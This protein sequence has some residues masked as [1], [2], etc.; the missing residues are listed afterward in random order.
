LYDLLYFKVNN[1]NFLDNV[2]YINSLIKIFLP[3]KFQNLKTNKVFFKNLLI[4]ELPKYNPYNYCY[5][6][7][8]KKIFISKYFTSNGIFFNKYL[9]RKYNI[10]YA[11]LLLTNS[12]FFNIILDLKLKQI[13]LSIKNLKFNFILFLYYLGIKNTD[14]L[15]YSRYKN[16]KI[17]KLLIFSALQTDL[18]NNKKII[19]KNLNY[20]KSIFKLTILNKNYKNFIISKD[21]LNYNYGDFSKNNLLIID[22]IFILDL[23]LDLQS[24][25]LC[26]KTIDHLDNKHINTIGNYFQHNFKFYLK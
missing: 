8:L 10:Y 26:F 9:K 12:N 14:I 11:K 13:Y 22:F 21:K 18:V 6:N 4:F 20:L 23:L 15:K 16:S 3:L 1:I 25:K 17:L 7:G 2:Q 5:L 19:L 24:K